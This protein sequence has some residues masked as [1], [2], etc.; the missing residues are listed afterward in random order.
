MKRKA[1]N[2]LQNFLTADDRKGVV[3]LPRFNDQSCALPVS[4]CVF[5]AETGIVL[6][7]SRAGREKNDFW[8]W[9]VRWDPVFQCSNAE[10]C[11][12]EVCHD[13]FWFFFISIPF[14][15]F[16]AARTQKWTSSHYILSRSNRVSC[17]FIFFFVIFF[18]QF[19]HSMKRTSPT[20]LLC[21]ALAL[22]GK[23]GRARGRGEINLMNAVGPAW[24]SHEGFGCG[25][26]WNFL[27][28]K[29]KK[30]F[31][32]LWPSERRWLIEKTSDG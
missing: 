32:K 8:S 29:L 12:E 19:I 24:C 7:C 25:N 5:E 31:S 22:N 14:F 4:P 11:Y 30:Y 6:D 13:L 9:S 21:L 15:L 18:F 23:R 3:C 1:D 16:F 2:D 10:T 27:A 28:V 26:A 20:W 17:V